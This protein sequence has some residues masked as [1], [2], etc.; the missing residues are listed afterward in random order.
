LYIFNPV[1]APLPFPNKGPVAPPNAP[2]SEPEPTAGNEA[3][4]AGL[5]AP[6]FNK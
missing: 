5:N 2:P 3:V 1:E 4:Y 6:L